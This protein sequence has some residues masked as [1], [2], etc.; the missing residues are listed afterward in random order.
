MREERHGL[1]GLVGVYHQVDGQV[2]VGK[3]ALGLGLHVAVAVEAQA[4]VACHGVVVHLALHLEVGDTAQ[5]VILNVLREV[6]HDVL[7][8]THDA[9][10]RLWRAEQLRATGV[11]HTAHH[12]RGGGQERVAVAAVEH[13]P[14]VVSLL[15]H[16]ALAKELCGDV[17]VLGYQL[18]DAVGLRHQ[19]RVGVVGAEV[20]PVVVAAGGFLVLELNVVE[21]L[22]VL[23]ESADDHRYEVAALV[24]ILSVGVH[25]PLVGRRGYIHVAGRAQV[26]YVELHLVP[27]V[28]VVL[29][30]PHA[31]GQA[32]VVELLAGIH[33][34]GL[35]RHG[36][37]L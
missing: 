26:V 17:A 8:G 29:L 10:H 14:Q 16:Y 32:L 11:L 35:L 6:E 15:E 21:V 2:L 7:T 33:L 9:V 30:R 37:G 34:Q 25:N 1:A 19:R 23:V 28:Q 12:L 20:R 36:A 4:D 3:V 13:G 5:V 22:L 31:D 18:L 24:V 27:G